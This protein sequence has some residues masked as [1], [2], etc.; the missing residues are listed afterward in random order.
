MSF[1]ISLLF[2]IK[3]FFKCNEQVALQTLPTYKLAVSSSKHKAKDFFTTDTSGV[4][5]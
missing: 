4:K 5:T 1:V 2:I 3:S